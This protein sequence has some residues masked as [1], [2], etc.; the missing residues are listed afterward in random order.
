VGTL[1]A[2]AQDDDLALEASALEQIVHALQRIGHGTSLKS[3]S[4]VAYRTR[5]CT[6]TI[7]GIEIMHMIKKGQLGCLGSMAI[8]PADYFYSLAAA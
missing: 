4:S 2:Y 6:R 3:E 1:P 5:I 7:A 8:S